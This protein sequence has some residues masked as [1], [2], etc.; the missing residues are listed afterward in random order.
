[1]STSETIAFT[2]LMVITIGFLVWVGWLI[3]RK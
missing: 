2:V 1:M 3:L